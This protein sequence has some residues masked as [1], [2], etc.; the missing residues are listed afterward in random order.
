MEP[1]QR[2]R[3]ARARAQ[4]TEYDYAPQTRARH[5]RDRILPRPDRW[6][7]MVGALEGGGGNI[8][9][10]DSRMGTVI[11]SSDEIETVIPWAARV[12]LGQLPVGASLPV[13]EHA[14]V[15][16]Y[17]EGR[18]TDAAARLLAVGGLGT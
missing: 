14:A 15:V 13:P 10:A 2:V 18:W 3:R 8:V 6:R 16:P 11:L 1:T 7:L 12:A 17:R 5:L 4:G 9:R